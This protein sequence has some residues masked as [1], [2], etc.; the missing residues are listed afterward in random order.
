MGTSS[1]CNINHRD[2]FSVHLKHKHPKLQLTSISVHPLSRIFSTHFAIIH[3]NPRF[4]NV[5]SL[6]GCRDFFAVYSPHIIKH[7]FWSIE[8]DGF[9]EV[10]PKI[11]TEK[12]FNNVKI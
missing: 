11:S 4:V 8:R 5:N 12:D 2:D 6:I 3:W 7:L 10:I 9:L 1:E